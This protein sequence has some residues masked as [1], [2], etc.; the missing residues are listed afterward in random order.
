MDAL[1]RIFP[2]PVTADNIHGADFYA[3]YGVA[4][5]GDVFAIDQPLG[6]YRVHRQDNG[7]LSLANAEDALA[8]RRQSTRRWVLLREIARQ[9]LGITLPAAPLRLRAGEGAVRHRAVRRRRSRSAGAGSCASPA[10][11]STPSPRTRTGA[12][13]RRWQVS[14]LTALALMPVKAISDRAIRFIANPLARSA[15]VRPVAPAGGD[16]TIVSINGR[17]LGRRP[18]GVDRFANEV[19]RS[20]DELVATGACPP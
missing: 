10:A 13:A 3:I 16:P 20:I 15:P 14:G 9:R 7:G 6:R 17:Y 8:G 1:R 19:I 2:V 12:C 11:T 18:T 5:A 4:L